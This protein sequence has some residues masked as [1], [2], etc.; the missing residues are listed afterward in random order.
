MIHF[1]EA[2][3]LI[4]AH[5]HPQAP[6][7]ASAEDALGRFL[8]DDVYASTPSPMFDNS[9]V[10]GYGRRAEDL[11][12]P[13]LR[14]A[15]AV[16]AGAS[17]DVVLR[18]GECVRIMTGAPVPEGVAA[19]AM[20]EDCLVEG[21]NVRFGIASQPG[22]HI[23]RIGSDF[24]AGVRLLPAGTRLGPAH[25]G[26]LFSGR[27]QSVSIHRPPRARIVSTGSELMTIDE[28]PAPGKIYDSNSFSLRQAVREMGIE[29][30]AT[31]A[32]DDPSELRRKL[33]DA[34]DEADVVITSGGVSVGD[35][36]LVRSTFASLGVEE[37]FWRVAIKPGMPV[38]FG[39][40][41]PKLAFGLPG[42]PV[43]AMVT[44]QLFVRPALLKLLGHRAPWPTPFTARFEGSARKKP[45]R[46][47]F[48][49]GDLGRDGTV[50]PLDRQS[51][52][53]LSGLAGA[54]CLIRF[55]VDRVELKPGD[56][57]EVTELRWGP[58]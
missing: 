33:G 3:S 57:V 21:E 23:R 42:N 27:A 32:G 44:F 48:L 10:D 19:V 58:E 20:Q 18:P 53:Q 41:G 9:A 46:M 4:E 6:I 15:G 2:A 5:T 50:R 25:G 54:N 12:A 49:R 45:G 16:A 47:E 39:V 40:Q 7:M 28:A 24:E 22:D 43:S 51:S 52:H 1:Q 34:L 13:S 29:C 8:A 36:D 37:L 14:L 55:P 35:F 17:P 30:E 31:R 11:D 38:S 56:P 26:L